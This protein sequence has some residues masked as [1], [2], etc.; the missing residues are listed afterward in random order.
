MPTTHRE[1]GAA[2]APNY[3]GDEASRELIIP[4]QRAE[5]NLVLSRDVEKIHR[6]GSARAWLELLLELGRKHDIHVE[7]AA[8]V[9]KYARLDPEL[10]RITG[11]NRMPPPPVYLVGGR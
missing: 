4:E 1:I 9:A 2:G 6:L 3:T 8:T 11:S 5:N 10:L 7:I